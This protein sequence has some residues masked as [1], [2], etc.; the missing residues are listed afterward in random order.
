[1]NHDHPYEIQDCLLRAICRDEAGIQ[2]FSNNQ[3]FCG[4]LIEFTDFELM[5]RATVSDYSS[6][7]CTTE[8]MTW[9]IVRSSITSM[10]VEQVVTSPDTLNDLLTL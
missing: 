7:M 6:G 1:M 10:C 9:V 4:Q 3:L 8:M 2:L 5:I